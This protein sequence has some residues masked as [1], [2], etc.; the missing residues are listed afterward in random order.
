MKDELKNYKYRARFDDYAGRLFNGPELESYGL[1]K[2]V[3]VTYLSGNQSFG[4]S[5]A[6]WIDKST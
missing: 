1:D 5:K 6:F 2:K 4:Y 3:L